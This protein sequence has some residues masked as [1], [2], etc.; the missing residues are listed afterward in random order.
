VQYLDKIK[1]LL[2][3]KDLKA[4]CWKG[5]S[6]DS[7]HRRSASFCSLAPPWHRGKRGCGLYTPRANLLG[8]R[9]HPCTPPQARLH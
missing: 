7:A 3:Q 8:T 6:C 1:K 9:K 5:T 4:W 2:P